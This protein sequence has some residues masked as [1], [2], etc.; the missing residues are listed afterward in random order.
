MRHNAAYCEDD[1]MLYAITK[2]YQPAK[3]GVN[4]LLHCD[5][6]NYDMAGCFLRD[7]RSQANLWALPKARALVCSMVALYGIC[8][9]ATRQPL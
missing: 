9:T 5:M 7:I 2:A 6:R 3:S 8:S 4:Q 1:G